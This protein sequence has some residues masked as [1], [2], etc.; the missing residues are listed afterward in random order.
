MRTYLYYPQGTCSTKME[1]TLDEKNVIEDFSVERGC[2]GNLKGIRALI[3][4]QKAEDVID[5]LEGI[6]CGM[7][8]TSCPD[9]IAKGLRL[10]LEGKLSEVER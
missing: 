7:K 9:Q 8:K 4:G 2:N 1:F 10:A 6:L 5:K 3:L